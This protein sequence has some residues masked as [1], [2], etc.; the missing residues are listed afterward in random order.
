MST[1][2]GNSIVGFPA[3]VPA[4]AEALPATEPAAKKWTREEYYR[5]GEQGWF[6]DQR[7]ELIDGEIIVLSPQSPQHVSGTLRVQRLLAK[8]IGT[9]FLIRPQGPLP[10]DDHSEPEPDIS[11]VRGSIEDFDEEHP[12][13]AVL[14]VEVS[15][16]SFRYD[17]NTKQHLYAS[18]GV[19]DYWVLDLSNRRLLVHREPVADESVPFGHRYQSLQT[20]DDAGSVS[21]LELPDVA[22]AIADMLPPVE[23]PPESSS[24]D[25]TT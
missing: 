4:L 25:A 3:P 14:V 18:M 20:I 15:K 11:V 1:T 12:T 16:T 9:G 23:M 17:T 22:L 21:P 2:T 7:V 19:E 6:H 10:K 5:L 13:S 24:D 8:V